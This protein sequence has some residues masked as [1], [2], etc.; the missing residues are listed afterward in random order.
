M[1]FLPRSN[2]PPKLLVVVKKVAE[3]NYEITTEPKLEPMIYATFVMT[4]KQCAKDFIVKLSGGKLNLSGE[5]PNF[6][7]I[8]NC[9]N[10]QSPIPVEL[11]M[12]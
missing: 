1:I 8:I 6:N 2:L 9:I 10:Q 12:I 7:A 3:T 5:N 4:F 11:Q